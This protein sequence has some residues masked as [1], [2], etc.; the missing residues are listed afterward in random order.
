MK[1]NLWFVLLIFVSTEIWAQWNWY[2]PQDTKS[3]N[4]AFIQNQG[5]N[6]D[7]GNYYRL[8]LRAR[9]VV[10]KEVWN[11]ACESA[12]LTVRFQTDAEDIKVRYQVTGGY[13]MPHMPATGVSGVD[14]YRLSKKGENEFCFGSYSF[15]DTVRYAYHIDKVDNTSADSEYVLYLPL[16]NGV[17][18]LE[19][20]IENN[21]KLSFIPTSGEKPL[22]L[23]G[24]SIA[25]GACASRPGMAWGNIVSRSMNIPLVNLGFSGNG[26]LEKEVL[27][28]I[29]EQEA[30]VYILDCIPNLSD[31]RAEEV[32]TL[33][34]NAV[35]QLREKHKTPILLVE[36]AGYSNHLTNEEQ[37]KSYTEANKGQ[38]LAMDEL[39][40]EGVKNLF[41]LSNKELN[42]HP[43][44]WVDYVHPSDWGMIQQADAIEK[45]LRKILK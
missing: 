24:T 36:H 23:Y 27:D 9:Q 41:Y 34:K 38:Q 35:Y 28:F 4:E 40:K 2:N 3:T 8:P 20:G 6:E 26:K 15:A 1:R 12:G 37:H 30:R 19:I 14:L 29:S 16:Y 13:S 31:R 25:Q 18:W 11:L 22:V 17:K 33:V 44:S 43:D 39:R 32:K 5:W 21:Y 42:Y 45:K 7:G 10:R